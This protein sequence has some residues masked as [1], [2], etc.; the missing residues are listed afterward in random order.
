MKIQQI[1]ERVGTGAITNMSILG[2][3]T[4]DLIITVLYQGHQYPLTN[5][6]NNNIK[7]FRSPKYVLN[8][9]REN[10]IN[11]VDV[12]LTQWDKTK[13]FDAHDRAMQLRKKQEVS[14]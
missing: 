10:G 4:G 7:V 1:A 5:T 2:L 9:L 8:Y 3:P 11:K 12:N 14:E 13:V 6:T